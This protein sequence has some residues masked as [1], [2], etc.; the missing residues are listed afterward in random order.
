MAPAPESRIEAGVPTTI[1][2]W[3][4]GDGEIATV[5]VRVGA[6]S[7][8]RVALCE[9]RRQRAW[10]RFS[11]DWIPE[12]AG[13]VEIAARATSYDGEK[14]PEANWRNCWHRVGMTVI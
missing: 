14:Q 7:P 4:W 9:A 13:P 3:A 1:W 5:E 6:D 10:Q 12:R 2:G 8:W 11:I